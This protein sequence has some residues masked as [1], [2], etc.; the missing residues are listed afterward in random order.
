MEDSCTQVEADKAHYESSVQG[1]NEEK[2]SKVCELE[3][4]L[5]FTIEGIKTFQNQNTILRDYVDQLSKKAQSMFYK[6]QCDQLLT[7]QHSKSCSQ[8]LPNKRRHKKAL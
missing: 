1:P 2:R 6:L 4:R 8:P 3:I 5:V 7:E